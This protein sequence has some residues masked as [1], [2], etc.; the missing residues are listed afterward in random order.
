MKSSHKIE[1]KRLLVS[2]TG[3]A[4]LGLAI[5]LLSWRYLLV[6]GGFPGYGLILNYL[7]DFPVGGFLIV[8]NTVILGLSFLIAGKTVGIKGVLGYIFLSLFIDFSKRF[9][10]LE[11]IPTDSFWQNTLLVI[12]Q[13]IAAPVGIAMVIINDYSFGSYSSILPIINRYRKI[14]PPM[15]FLLLDLLLTGI[16]YAFFGLEKSVLLLINATVFF[17]AFRFCLT[18]FE[19]SWLKIKN[20]T[21]GI[22]KKGV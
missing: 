12:A 18:R 15:L 6:S 5:N 14:S 22:G 4:I 13:G 17:L 16:T 11:Q 19:R 8:A 20:G 9:L 7:T 1:I 10:R 2:L 21:E 3:M